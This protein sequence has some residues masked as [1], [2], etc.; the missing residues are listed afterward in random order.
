MNETSMWLPIAAVLVGFSAAWLVFEVRRAWS[1]ESLRTVDRSSAAPDETEAL[2]RLMPTLV[3]EVA[4]LRREIAAVRAAE[5]EAALRNRHRELLLTQA[6]RASTLGTTATPLADP[7]SDDTTP[8]ATTPETLTD[9]MWAELATAE[10]ATPDDLPSEDPATDDATADTDARP[11][12]TPADDT[13]ADDTA[14]DLPAIDIPW[15]Y[16]AIMGERR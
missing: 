2:N 15:P 4:Q 13:P 16:A 12:D 11:E 3:E 1:P 7:P 10:E 9:D 5:L 6:L 8:D 14:T